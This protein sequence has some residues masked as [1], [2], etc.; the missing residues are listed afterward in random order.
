[1]SRLALLPAKRFKVPKTSVGCDLT[2]PTTVR[3]RFGTRQSQRRWLTPASNP[4]QTIG[5]HL[6]TFH[7]CLSSTKTNCLSARLS[8]ILA[9]DRRAALAEEV[10]RIELNNSLD[11][12]VHRQLQGLPTQKATF[13]TVRRELCAEQFEHLFGGVLHRIFDGFAK[14]LFEQH[15][16]RGLADDTAVTGK[17]AIGDPTL[18]VKL[19]L[20]PNNIAAQRIFFFVSVRRSV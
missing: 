2:Y 7:R 19:K 5:Q 8:A 3:H 17:V 9:L 18:V 10:K 20:D 11:R 16:G 13:L 6:N 12:R 14:H 1:M 4:V 15:R